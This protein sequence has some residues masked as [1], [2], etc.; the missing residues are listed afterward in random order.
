MS[1]AGRLLVVALAV[2]LGTVLAPASAA[3]ASAPATRPATTY[4]PPTTLLE[5]SRFRYCNNAPCDP[6][7]QGY[8]RGPSG[9]VP[10]ADNP[11]GFIRVIPGRRITWTYADDACDAFA[12]PPLDCP[13]H[14][15]RL[16]N[17]TPQGSEPL[18]F[19]PGRTPGPGRSSAT[20]AA[21]GTTTP[22]ASPASS[23]WS[24]RSAADAAIER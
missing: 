2:C 8:V 23:R 11:A 6:D 4:P 5:V 24:T 13:G 10:G 7:A 17:G 19:L 21:S 15:V 16:E 18:G 22:V 14:E 20:S 9:P 1:R 12:T 3:R